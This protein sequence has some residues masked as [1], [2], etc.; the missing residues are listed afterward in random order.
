MKIAIIG[1]SHFGPIL[2][3]QL[4]EFDKKNSYTF[5]NTNADI[6][7]KIKFALSLPIIDVVYSISAT[8]SGGGALNLALKFNK[9]IVQHFI[10]SDVLTAIEDYK[11]CNTSKKLIRKSRYLCEVSWIQN[12]LQKINIS[13]EM[14]S[15]M[16]CDLRMEPIPFRTFSVLTYIGKG[17]ENFYGVNDFIKLANHFPD[18][19]FKIAGIEFYK[20]LPINVKCLGWINMKEEL[21][22]TVVFIRNAEHDGLGFSVV[23]ALSLGRVVLRNYRFPYVNYFEN[24]DD[25]IEYIADAKRQFEEGSLEI[26]YS[27][28]EFVKKE[29]SKSHVLGNLIKILTGGSDK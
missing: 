2:T 15:F 19:E 25:M 24:S 29:Y 7:D 10:G 17:K 11:S 20:G 1:N 12:E 21:Q 18:V 28:I 27:E 23:E 13:A 3:K 8:I 5:Y 22:K 6:V 14:F 9:K 4:S 16:V 26:N